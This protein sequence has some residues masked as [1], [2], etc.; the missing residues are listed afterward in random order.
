MTFKSDSPNA[1]DEDIEAR[2][3]K[4]KQ[5]A[6]ALTDGTMVTGGSPDCPR[7]L[8]EQFWKRVI[9]FE[10]GTEVEVVPFDLL[11]ESGFTLP[12]PDELDDTRLTAK[13]WEVIEAM[14]ALGLLLESTDHLSDRELYVRLW[15]DVLR[16]PTAVYPDATVEVH[17]DL[18]GSG[19]DEDVRLYLKY[20]ADEGE[21][22]SWAEDWPEFPMPEAA[23]PPYDR[24][25]HLP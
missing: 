15:T 17:I 1:P 12:A 18:V 5:R 11:V 14:S 10:E 3:E 2:I 21:R 6:A 20:Y 9:A 16:E 25:R 7:E 22:R 19:S 24:D 13:L 4:L 8:Q 23:R